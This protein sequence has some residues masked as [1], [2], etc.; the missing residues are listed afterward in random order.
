M[1]SVKPCIKCGAQDRY[2]SG[3]CRPC[4]REYYAANRDTI[5]K[6]KQE[7]LAANREKHLERCRKYYA[8]N[9]DKLLENKRE[10]RAV[11]HEM[12]REYNQKYYAANRDALTK[13]HRAYYAA[14]RDIIVKQKVKY[15]AANPDKGKANQLARRTRKL[16][17]GGTLTAADVNFIR[18]A[19]PV[20]LCCGIDT[21]LSIDH[22]IPLAR[23]GRNEIDNAQILCRSCNS[24]KGIKTIDYRQA[25][26]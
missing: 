25:N 20:C 19:F 17:N 11:N 23:G 24:S 15:R 26:D 13:Q 10:Y 22:V 2:V 4:K 18:A 16:N 6:Q 1:T 9:R 7:H 3:Q 5:V 14:N 21:T 8:A 12:R